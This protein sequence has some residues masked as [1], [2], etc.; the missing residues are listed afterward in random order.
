MA[1]PEFNLPAQPV[2]LVDAQGTPYAASGGAPTQK[3]V[4]AE[5]GGSTS[6]TASTATQVLAADASR[7]KFEFQNLGAQTIVLR[8]N[9]GS[10]NT[11]ATT[12][13]PTNKRMIYVPAGQLYVSESDT[14]CDGIIS[15]ASTSTSV[16]FTYLAS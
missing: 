15:V 14:K 1:L 2:V 11:A 5:G 13:T 9:Q 4:R 7:T 3:T 12:A 6:G 16:P 8:I 10:D